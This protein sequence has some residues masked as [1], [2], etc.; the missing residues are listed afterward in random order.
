MQRVDGVREAEAGGDSMS[1]KPR[2]GDYLCVIRVEDGHRL[3]LGKS[4]ASAALAWIQGTVLA[5]GTDAMEA[6]TEA[7]KCRTQQLNS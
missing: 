7:E 4:V 3:Y 5:W 1:S 2:P 6:Q